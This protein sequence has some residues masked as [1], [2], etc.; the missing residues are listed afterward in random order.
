MKKRTFITVS[1][2]LCGL[3]LLMAIACLIARSVLAGSQQS[4]KQGGFFKSWVTWLLLPSASYPSSTS[5]QGV[6]LVHRGS[7]TTSATQAPGW[8]ALPAAVVVSR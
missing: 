2:I 3:M 4:Q 8:K 6:G 7:L 5:K 1:L